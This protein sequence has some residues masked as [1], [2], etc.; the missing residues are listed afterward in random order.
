MSQT[1]ETLTS[2]QKLKSPLAWVGGKSKLTATLIP[3]IPPHQCYVEV[4]AGAAW[5]LFRKPPVKTE[6]INDINNDLVTLYRVIQNH[7]PEFVRQFEWSLISRDEF[8]RQKQVPNHTLTDIQR[9]VRFYY[10]VKNSFGAKLTDQSFGLAK[11]TKPRLNIETMQDNLT[12]IKQRLA[13]VFIE[14]LPYDQLIKRVDWEGAFFYCDPPYWDC[15]NVYGKGIFSKA[16]FEKLR[17]T[18]AGIKGK[19]MMSINDTPQIRELFKQFNIAEVDTSYSLNAENHKPV[20]EL[21]IT[22]YN[23]PDTK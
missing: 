19:F 16:D 7:L 23:L 18:L 15:E 10:L 6:I 20:T 14:N 11:T 5:M 21:I 4:F 13:H 3:L 12:I 8:E 17:D 2:N 22:N 1:K 9:A